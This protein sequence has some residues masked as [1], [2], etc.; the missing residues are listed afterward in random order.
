M[1]D[2]LVTR[3][4]P[5]DHPRETVPTGSTRASTARRAQDGTARE[6]ASM[7]ENVDD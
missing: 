3:L 4:T 6:P 5:S 7:T 1:H 2:S